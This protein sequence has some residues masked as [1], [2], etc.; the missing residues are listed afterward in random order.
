MKVAVVERN[1]L[2]QL[3][4]GSVIGP[5]GRRGSPR[6]RMTRMLD[7][8]LATALEKGDEF[9]VAQFVKKVIEALEDP[10]KS[11]AAASL[12]K[13]A[14]DRIWPAINLHEHRDTSEEDSEA[15]EAR[16]SRLAADYDLRRS[17]RA[18]TTVEPIVD[19]DGSEGTQ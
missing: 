16:W 2:G 7:A 15:G 17:K 10:T 8:Q 19:V 14:L 1:E 9:S 11:L 3:L 13:M 5:N 12:A 6:A 18:A 4:P